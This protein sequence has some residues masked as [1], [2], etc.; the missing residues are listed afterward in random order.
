S[1]LTV[2]VDLQIAAFPGAAAARTAE[3]TLVQEGV[4][5]WLRS[6]TWWPAALSL[7]RERIEPAVDASAPD[8]YHR[9]DYD[10]EVGRSVRFLGGEC[11]KSVS[12]LWN[13]QEILHERKPSLVVEFGTNRGG[14]ALFFSEIL[15][16]V[17]P[18]SRVLTVD[19]NSEAVSQIVRQN[20]HIEVLTRSTTD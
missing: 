7:P 13:Y 14:S 5:R 11:W 9:W 16:Q 6:A 18:Q 15:K 1:A 8:A 10:R 4:A 3:V 12:D 2:D 17:S 20:P 19:V